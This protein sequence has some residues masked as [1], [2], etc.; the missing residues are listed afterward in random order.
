MQLYYD[1]QAEM[2]LKLPE[3]LAS[4]QYRDPTDP[5][6]TAFKAASG[7]ALWTWLESHSDA[8]EH[9][10]FALEAHSDNLESLATIYPAASLISSSDP[11][12]VLI[13]D[14]GGNVGYD[15]ERFRRQ[16]PQPEGRL[17]LQD[18]QEVI[19]EART[20]DPSIQKTPYDFFTPQPVKGGLK[21]V[22]KRESMLMLILPG[23]AAYYL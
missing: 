20:V 17:V 5:V 21:M 9:L 7:E 14:V 15:L 13:V 23:A 11:H 12:G 3:Y 16:Y 18:R 1:Y 8:N 10:N 22:R 2:F 6:N 4:I 19:S